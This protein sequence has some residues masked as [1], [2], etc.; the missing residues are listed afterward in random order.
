MDSGDYCPPLGNLTTTAI[1]RPRKRSNSIC[2]TSAYNPVSSDPNENRQKRRKYILQK[3]LT[4]A[5]TYKTLFAPF[6]MLFYILL[7]RLIYL[8]PPF[9][10]PFASTFF[11]SCIIIIRLF[12]AVIRGAQGAQECGRFSQEYIDALKASYTGRSNYGAPDYECSFCHAIFWY[13]ERSTYS[14]RGQN[15]I[16]YHLCCKQGKIQIPPY[17]NRLEPLSSLA[18]F[19]GGTTSKKFLKNIWQ[20]NCLFAFTSMGANIDRS[21][22]DGRGPPVFK[23]SG[24]VHHRIGSLLPPEGS[25]P[26]FLQLY[27][28]DTANEVSNRLKAL[29]SD[30][31]SASS[32][33]PSI[34]QNLTAMLDQHNPF[35]KKFR[36]ARDRLEQNCDDE[37]VIRIVGAQEGDPVQYNL[38]TTDQ[39]SPLK[40]LNGTSLSKQNLAIQGIYH[41]FI[42]HTC[43]CSIH[44]CF[45]SGSVASRL[46][47]FIVV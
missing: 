4:H 28:Y 33:D 21:V 45:L 16:D 3:R 11:H 25:P 40:H 12:I 32:L 18:T 34:I 22:N 39:I 29:H 42:L 13:R 23:I 7:S 9:A 10:S 26:K 15:N 14:S 38:P 24:Q 27:I 20:Y 37:F 35:A 8:Q 2:N 43:P 41:L 19:N 5:G 1:K 17:K 36:M 30:D 44:C 46:V 31:G 6:Q 47:F